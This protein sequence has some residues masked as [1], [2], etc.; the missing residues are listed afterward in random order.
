MRLAN[1]PGAQFGG[2]TLQV[3]GG[4]GVFVA[5]LSGTTGEVQ[6]AYAMGGSGL[7]RAQGLIVDGQGNVYVAGLYVTPADSGP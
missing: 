5:K 7:D 3:A 6:R 1:T 2:Y 4:G